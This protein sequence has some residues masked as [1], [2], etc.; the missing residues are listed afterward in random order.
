[1]GIL[2]GEMTV[3]DMRRLLGDWQLEISAGFD[4]SGGDFIFFRKGN[5]N[6]ITSL[7]APM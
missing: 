6:V 4:C 7:Y 3:P 1:M 5:E 2:T